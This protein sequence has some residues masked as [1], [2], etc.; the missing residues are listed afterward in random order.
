MRPALFNYVIILF[1][2][3][4]CVNL[5]GQER[6]LKKASENFDEYAFADAR[7]LYLK[8]ANDGYTSPDILQ[9]LGDSYYLTAE[10]AEAARWYARLIEEVPEGSSIDPEYY[11]RYAQSLKSTER[12]DLA[13]EQMSTF[14]ALS[15]KDVRG[16]MFTAERDY[17]KEIQ[18]QSGRFDV[19][20]VNFNSELQDFGPSFYGDRLVFSSNRKSRTGDYIHDWNDQPFLDLFIVENPQ[21]A[22]PTIK[23][24][25]DVVNTPYHESTT[26]FTK[27][28]D[29]FYFTRNNYSKEYK[30]KNLKQDQAGVTKLKIYRSVLLDNGDWSLPE[31]LPFNSDE[32]STAHPALSPDEKT[33]YFASDRP[34]TLGLSDL[35]KV[36]IHTD[37]SFGDPVN[38]GERINTEARETFPFLS[39]SNE[40]FF[41]TDGHVGL[42]GL[43]VFV[44]QLNNEGELQESH[45]VGMP[46]NSNAD[47]FG[48]IINSKDGTGYFSSNRSTGLGNDDIYAIKRTKELMTACEQSIAGQTKD[49]KTDEILPGVTVEL[50]NIQNEIVNTAISDQTGRFNFEN[51]SCEASYILR[52]SKDTY[53]PFEATINTGSDKDG[54]VSRDLYLKA[55]LQVNVGDDLA[56]TLSLNPIY[57]DYDKDYIRSDAAIELQKV[58]ALMREYPNLKI[59]VR[60]HTDSRGRDSYN[61]NLS[62]R[63]NIATKEYIINQGGISRNRITGKGYG[64]TQ[65][66]NGCR[67]GVKCSDEEHQLNRRS[68][69]IVIEK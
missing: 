2:F 9:K 49:V 36:S 28:K 26:A 69:F 32:F 65:L 45:N 58:I 50:R 42:G 4:F 43:D 39:D 30:G 19:S 55:P 47:D 18:E 33:L 5:H 13:D 53:D 62:Q 40:L 48:F 34:G 38:L 23:K 21:G 1:V 46:I 31:E 59:D 29:V 17:L 3:S 22:T 20:K 11:F 64:E 52:G 41:A 44:N 67:N 15:G 24:F 54:V 57:F 35:W 66:V 7:D 51:I 61:L 63:R 14:I 60:S 37:G 16:K 25:T 12:Y 10:Y 68:E 56:I 27:N 8:V 6:K